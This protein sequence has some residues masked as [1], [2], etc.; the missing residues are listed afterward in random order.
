[1]S[2][3]AM[4]T[5]GVLTDIGCHNEQPLCVVRSCGF[6]KIGFKRARSCSCLLCKTYCSLDGQRIFLSRP[7]H[8]KPK[9]KAGLASKDE[10]N[11]EAATLAPDNLLKAGRTEY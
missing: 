10:H 9:L 5:S 6:G 1:M 11:V 2:R 7:E 3:A 8:V 4:E